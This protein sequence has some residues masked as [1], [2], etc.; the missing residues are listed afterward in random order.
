MA[1]KTAAK[2]GASK[3]K[4]AKLNPSELKLLLGLKEKFTDINGK[5][6]SLVPLTMADQM[7][8]EEEMK[9]SI[10]E[11][12]ADA[13]NFQ[14]KDVLFILWL[15]LRKEGLTAD[16][17]DAE[18]WTHKSPRAVGNMFGPTVEGATLMVNCFTALMIL[19][20]YIDLDEK[21]GE[22]TRKN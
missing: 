3:A 17:I 1:T 18:Q 5:E 11:I 14:G 13:E 7:D 22:V 21:T 10:E 12:G 4:P 9:A 19:S 20:G 2:K 6:H 8:L 16:E 15:S